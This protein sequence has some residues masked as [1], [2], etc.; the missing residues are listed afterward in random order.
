MRR[1][2][3]RAGA[4]LSLACMAGAVLIAA[5]PP[6]S[7]AEGTTDAGSYLAPFNTTGDL[8]GDD[9][10]TQAD[11]DLLAGHVGATSTDAAWKTVAAADLDDDGTITVT[12]VA[13]LSQKMI[14]DDGPFELVEASVLDMQAAMNAGVTSSV[15]L[16]QQYLDRIK[17]YDTATIDTAERGRPLNSIISTN[18]EALKLAAAADEERKDKGMTSVLLGIPVLLKDNYDTKDMPTTAGCACWEENQTDD[19]AEMVEGLRSQGAVVMAKASLDEFA[20]GFS[21]QFSAFQGMTEDRQNATSIA[22]PYNTSKTAGGSSGGTG[23][24]ISANLAAL[25][26]GTDTGGSIRVPS[27]YNQLVGVRPTVGLAS[28]DGIVPLALSQDTGGPMT[29]SVADAAIA[30]DAVVGVDANDVATERQRGKVPNSYTKYLDPQALAG[31][32]IGYFAQMIPSPTATNAAQAAAGRRFEQAKADLEAQGATVVPVEMTPDEATAFTRVLNEGSGSTNEFKHDLDEY[33]ATHLSPAVE[34]NTLQGIIDSGKFTPAYRST[35]VS[36]DKIT[37]ETY[38]AWAGPDGTHTRQLAL[39]H[40]QVTG[41]LDAQEI[42]AVV[43][44]SGTPFGTFS[45]NMRLSPN[46]GMP[47]VTVPMGADATDPSAG[48]NLEFLGRQF[49]EGPLLG[50]AYAYEQ[51]TGHRTTP[52]LFGP[53]PQEAP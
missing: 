28:R 16:T 18:P 30:L 32:K 34:A 12:D 27:S 17:A 22:S 41:L 52:T 6:A 15:A 42:D 4:A 21:S 53:L 1:T 44:P 19:D 5:G 51:A 3:T 25:G 37:E 13:A 48:M 45:T 2:P 47:A 10:I 49:D 9:A 46:T 11:V 31:K 39:G 26:F 23:A 8:T 40:E 50:L 36:R 35:Y 29:R 43:Y 7:S 14:Y 20:Y 38:Q 24:S 33:M